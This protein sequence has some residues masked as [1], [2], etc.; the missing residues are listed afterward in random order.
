[1]GH[2]LGFPALPRSLPYPPLQNFDCA[3]RMLRKRKI[4]SI[5]YLTRQLA[6]CNMVLWE[7]VRA[8]KTARRL[9]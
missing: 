8:K 1:M 4:S 9:V 2:G 5:T 6:L 7:S 3:P